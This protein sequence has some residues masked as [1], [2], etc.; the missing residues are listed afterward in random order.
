MKAMTVAPEDV[1]GASIRHV[2]VSPGK[3]SFGCIAMRTVVE[4]RSGLRFELRSQD[5]DDRTP[6]DEFSES[7]ETWSQAQVLPSG[8]TVVGSIIDDVVTCELWPTIGLWL[9]GDDLLYNSN[10]YNIRVVGP[11]LARLGGFYKASDLL[12]FWGDSVTISR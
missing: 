6:I 1:R 10:E 2:W 7:L 3:V 5:P 4:L 8:D 9:R 12:S 11:C